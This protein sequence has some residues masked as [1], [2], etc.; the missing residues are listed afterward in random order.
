MHYISNI[1]HQTISLM[2]NFIIV[3]KEPNGKYTAL[4]GMAFNGYDAAEKIAVRLSTIHKD[5]QF[6]VYDKENKVQYQIELQK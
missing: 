1:I 2:K 4:K 5:R 6:I 3:E